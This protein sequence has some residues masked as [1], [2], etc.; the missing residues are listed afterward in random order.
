MSVK[1][2]VH[3]LLAGGLVVVLAA[4]LSINSCLGNLQT[5]PNQNGGFF[6]YSELTYIDPVFGL[7][8]TIPM[9]GQYVNGAWNGTYTGGTPY[10]DVLS[11]P[12]GGSGYARTDYTGTLF[13]GN[14]LINAYWNFGG[15]WTFPCNGIQPFV[16]TN[17]PITTDVPWFAMICVQVPDSPGFNT[18]SPQFSIAGATPAT[19]TVTS[20]N[21]STGA[22]MPLLYVWSFGAAAVQP[23]TLISRS[24]ATS[25]SPDG[26]TATFNFPTYNGGAVPSGIY[27]YGLFNQ[28]SAGLQNAGHGLLS[29]GTNST[30]QSPFGVDVGNIQVQNKCQ[31]VGEPQA[32]NGYPQTSNTLSPYVTLY[33]SAAVKYSGG[34]FPV[35]TQPTAIKLY[36]K[37]ITNNG[38]CEPQQAPYACYTTWITQPAYALVANSGS[39][40]VSVVDL[41]NGVAN[42]SISVGTQPVALLLSATLAPKY[43]YVANYG[44]GTVSQV[45]L[46]TNTVTGTVTA[47]ADPMALALDPSGTSFWVGGLNYISKVATSNLAI[48]STYS[49]AGQVTSLAIAGQQDALLYTLVTSN[50]YQVAQSKLSTGAF[51]QSYA[52]SSTA[53]YSC[54]G[55][56]AVPVSLLAS[57]LLV[58]ANYSNNAVVAATPTGFVVLDLSTQK[59]IVQGSTVTPIRSIATDPSQG[60]IYLTVPSSNSVLSVP[61]PPI[62][63]H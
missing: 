15:Q 51:V 63:A 21:L 25:V 58:A 35:G 50:S 7:P 17:V 45:N 34:T 14:G 62:A 42:A 55:C 40:T 5:G 12:S 33:N 16:E 60:M 28:Q 32:C 46:Q 37:S 38:P 43:A 19:L 57:G 3:L 6:V 10:G 8:D 9:P 31:E 2:F 59:Q 13:V 52:Q 29:I 49:V 18:M 20:S 1:G 61:L 36:G 39:A 22:G 44:S 41:V 27:S 11:F 47:G 56:N 4:L 54:Q 23:P 30:Y 24:S 26:K 48:T 53:N